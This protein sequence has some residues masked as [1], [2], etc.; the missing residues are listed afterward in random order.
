MIAKPRI[1]KNSF[2]RPTGAFNQSLIGI[3]L[4]IYPF[5]NLIGH[6]AR[7]SGELDNDYLGSHQCTHGRGGIDVL[8]I[9]VRNTI[10]RISDNLHVPRLNDFIDEIAGGI[11]VK[12]RNAPST[13]AD[14]LGSNGYFSAST[15]LNRSFKSGNGSVSAC[16]VA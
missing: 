5:M 2:H 6:I 15:S 11:I 3:V 4:V 10:N 12:R 14:Y 8:V 1:S 9:G 7:F 16:L 13:H